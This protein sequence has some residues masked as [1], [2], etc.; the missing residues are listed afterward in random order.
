MTQD[1]QISESTLR[2]ELGQLRLERHELERQIRET[3]AKLHFLKGQQ[4]KNSK[5][6]KAV[7]KRIAHCSEGRCPVELS[8]SDRP[9]ILGLEWH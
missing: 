8:K 1:V 9:W 6:I 3:Q 2:C 7:K 4:A 5:Q